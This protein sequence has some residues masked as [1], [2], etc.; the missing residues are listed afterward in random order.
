MQSAAWF[1]PLVWR[2]P[3]AHNLACEQEADR[4]AS[5][6]WPDRSAYTRLLAQLALRVYAVSPAEMA[7]TL[8]GASQIAKRI[9]LLWRD[10]FRPWKWWDSMAGLGLAAALA[11]AAAGWGFSS[12]HA[13]EAPAAARSN[14]DKVQMKHYMSAEWHFSLD[15]P[16]N[17]NAFPPVSSNS[18][19]EV[20]RFISMEGGTHMLI[21][22][23]S[24]DNPNE[25]L[26]KR[27][28][29]AQATLAKQGFGNFTTAIAPVGSKSAATLDFD[30]KRED[31]KTWSCRE[32]F[33]DDG[34][35]DYVL[36]F[37][38]TDKVGMFDLYERMAQSFQTQE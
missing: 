31:G 14:A 36:G 10:G 22:F 27:A 28:A 6:H 18:P 24:A 8:N 23:R 21:V 4:I 12:A 33:I 16:R 37:G 30:R 29:N 19:F 11:L 20:I 13:A 17:W 38:T 25:P 26:A 32:Y 5:S 9:E 7:L 34:T 35:L 3:A 1:H 15:I 2:I